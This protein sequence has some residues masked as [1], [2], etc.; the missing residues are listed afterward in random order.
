MNDG[1]AVIAA[2]PS[3]FMAASSWLPRHDDQVF[4]PTRS[5]TAACS[6]GNVDP[7]PRGDRHRKPAISSPRTGT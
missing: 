4:R 2:V 3:F 6:A 5:V 1:T 7:A